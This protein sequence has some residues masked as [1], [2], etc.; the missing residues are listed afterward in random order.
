MGVIWNESLICL[1]F[2]I[3]NYLRESALIAGICVQYK[4]GE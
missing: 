3:W 4:Q 2:L 1:D